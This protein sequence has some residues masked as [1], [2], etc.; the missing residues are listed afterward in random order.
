MDVFVTYWSIYLFL[1][2]NGKMFKIRMLMVIT[3][4]YA[5]TI[6]LATYHFVNIL[7]LNMLTLSAYMFAHQIIPF[8]KFLCIYSYFCTKPILSSTG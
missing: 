6:L 5:G 8:F 3:Y 2:V 7:D 1:L 4:I